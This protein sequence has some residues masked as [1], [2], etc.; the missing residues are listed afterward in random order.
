[1]K[2]VLD[3]NIPFGLEAFSTLG[4]VHS[5]SGREITADVVRDASIVVVRSMTK[6]NAQ[7]LQ[8]S[9]VQIVGTVTAGID[10]IDCLYLAQNQI[11]LATAFGANANAVAEYVMT[12]LL[13]WAHQ[14]RTHLVG[15]TLGVMGVGNIGSLVIEKARALGMNVILH[16]PPLARE[17]RDAHYRSF[18]EVCQADFITLH[19]PL[20]HTGPDAT[21][22]LFDESRIAKLSPH[23][24][25]LNTSRGEVIDNRALSQAVFARRI[26]P[27]I[28]DVWE[29]EPTLHWAL[30]D[31][32]A[33]ATPH[34]AG[35]SFDG[36]V[37][38]TTMVYQ[39]ICQILGKPAIW[40]PHLPDPD[41][42]SI[43]IE[44]SQE[45]EEEMLW[46]IVTRVYDLPNDHAQMKTLLSLPIEKRA[47]AF[48][49]LRKTYP[50]RREFRWTTVS[51]PNG[52]ASLRNRIAGLGFRLTD[53]GKSGF[54]W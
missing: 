33:L 28:L 38:G 46:K 9:Q 12:A 2:I 52:T 49:V 16:D 15:K 4:E 23:V 37:Q 7:L 11:S 24:L 32:A 10:H 5:V 42:P 47:S 20:T 8:N 36:K 39:A 3:H 54:F 34:I 6:I 26:R 19:V 31:Q 53:I 44:L 48:D 45:E 29:G 17:T 50:Q 43:D 14:Q 22:H 1:M 35:H 27:P 21:Y 51:L 25:L 13:V 18:E 30:V 40:T 41:C